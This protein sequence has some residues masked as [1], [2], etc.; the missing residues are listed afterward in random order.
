MF[1]AD[2]FYMTWQHKIR[3]FSTDLCDIGIIKQ[4]PLSVF[5]N[6]H[7]ESCMVGS[8]AVKHISSGGQAIMTGTLK[9]TRSR[10]CCNKFEEFNLK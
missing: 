3:I 9:T 8:R 7:R 4:H 10:R 5:R 6:N 2:V 1:E